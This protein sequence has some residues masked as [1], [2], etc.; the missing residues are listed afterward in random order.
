MKFAG[1]YC[2]DKE[3][4]ISKVLFW[5]PQHGRRRCG[6]F[7]LSYLKLLENDMEMM[8]GKIQSTMKDRDLW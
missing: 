2:Q 8:V 4:P 7:A 6:R 5:M 3:E 1:H